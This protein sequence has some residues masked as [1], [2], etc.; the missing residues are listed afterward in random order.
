MRKKKSEIDEG[1]GRKRKSFGGG[2]SG[3]SAERGGGGKC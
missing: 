2:R 3:K 1:D